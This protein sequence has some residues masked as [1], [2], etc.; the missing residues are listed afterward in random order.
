[1]WSYGGAVTS[2]FKRYPDAIFDYQ[3]GFPPLPCNVTLPKE[4]VGLQLLVT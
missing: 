1:M 3:S 4:L 2:N